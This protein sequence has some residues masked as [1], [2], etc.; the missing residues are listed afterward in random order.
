MKQ[1]KE[2]GK[3]KK[4]A[5]NKEGLAKGFAFLKENGAQKKQNKGRRKTQEEKDRAAQMMLVLPVRSLC[6]NSS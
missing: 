5:M 1:Q 4:P 3:E 2:R 6:P